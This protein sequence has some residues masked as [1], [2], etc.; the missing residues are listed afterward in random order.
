MP[1]NMPAAPPPIGGLDLAPAPAAARGSGVSLS[2]F[3]VLAL[4]LGLTAAFDFVN[5]KLLRLPRQ[6][7]LLLIALVASLA[8]IGIDELARLHLSQDASRLLH[9]PELPAAFLNGALSFLLFAGALHVDAGRLWD[10]KWTILALVT[11]GLGLAILIMGG[12]MWLA[13]GLIGFQVPLV[14]CLV[15]GAIVAPTDP[16]AV[17][18]LIA[19]VRLPEGLQATIVGESLFNDGVAVVAF[20]FLLEFANGLGA[21]IGPLTVVGR[22]GLEAVGGGLLGALLGGLAYAMLR[23]IDDHHLEGLISLALATVTYALAQHLHVSAPIAVVVAGLLTGS[24]AKRMAMSDNTKQQVEQFWS[25]IDEGLNA[26]L[27]LLIGFEITAVVFTPD[28]LLIGVAAIGVA[29][30]A[31]AVSVTA[32]ALPLHWRTPGRGAG[33]VVLIWGGLRG[34]ISVALAL[35]LPRGDF[36]PAI[37]AATY[38]VVLFT[39][40]VQGLTLQPLIRRLDLAMPEP[41]PPDAA[42]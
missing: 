6:I 15:L 22:F 17:V 33:I 27:F 13:F 10:R 9:L 14:W 21:E 19:R 40:I 8:V 4:L 12:G 26:V 36:R 31:R 29:L 5:Y 25:L 7:G 39:I 38:G 18:G 28:Y 3:D 37:L 11:L 23:Q 34:G 2:G 16:I 32:A 42:S 41:E 30:V 24:K 35:T 20:A 1:A